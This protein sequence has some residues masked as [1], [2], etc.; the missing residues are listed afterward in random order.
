[1]HLDN[2]EQT[3][4]CVRLEILRDESEREE[5]GQSKVVERRGERCGGDSI[6]DVL[7]ELVWKEFEGTERER[8]S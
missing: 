2:F 8:R 1:M 3:R 6:Q 7:S 4:L 5:E